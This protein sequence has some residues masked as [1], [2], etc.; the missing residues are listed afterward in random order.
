[1]TAGR[2]RVV[3]LDDQITHYRIPLFAYLARQPIALT[4]FYCRASLTSRVPVLN[5]DAS[6]DHRVLP[7]WVLRMTRPPFAE[8][9]N[10]LLNPTLPWELLSLRPDV[11][12]GY[13]F[14][15]PTWIAFSY[16]RLLR[17]G[18]VSWS[19]DTLHTERHLGAGQRLARRMIIP[20]ADACVALSNGA[21][22]KY[23]AYGAASARIRVSVQASGLVDRLDSRQSS[24]PAAGA[25]G[26]RRSI[27]YV[28]A[29][30]ER[31]GVHYLMESFATIHQRLPECTLVLAGDG[32]LRERL[33]ARAVELGLDG[34]VTFAGFVLPEHLPEYYLRTGLFIFPTLEDTF[35]VVIAEAAAH[36]LPIVTSQ[37]AGA[38]AEFVR[39]AENGFVVEPTDT[40]QL[41]QAALRILEDPDLQ[42]RMGRRSREIAASHGLEVAGQQFLEAIELSLNRT[43]IRVEP[44]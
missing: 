40:G 21:K 29:L 1:M 33:Q 39:E 2:P 38:S 36:G 8:P 27:L 42:L 5:V 25:V 22:E 12:V 13:S 44:E 14:S 18:F 11:V 43:R 34:A 4:V 16:A 10:I 17:K 30:S 35:G 19:G 15:I 28:G 41:A 24:H 3:I 23:L 6:F 31:K 9:R 37:Y 20:R 26:R 7:G 32:S